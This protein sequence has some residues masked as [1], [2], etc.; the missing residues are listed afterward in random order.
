MDFAFPILSLTLI[1]GGLTI[2]VSYISAEQVLIL[3]KRARPTEDLSLRGM[4]ERVS[5]KMGVKID[6]VYELEEDQA[7]AYA[8]DSVRKIVI[9][10]KSILS[11]VNNEELESIM[12]HEVSHIKA[13]HGLKRAI[14]K[15]IS[16]ITLGSLLFY[17]VPILIIIAG[18]FLTLITDIYFSKTTELEA[19]I[20]ASK[21]VDKYA[22][23]SAISKLSGEESLFSTH[24]A[25]SRRISSILSA[26]P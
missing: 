11:H 17:G 6:Q 21:I 2:I 7:N 24:P 19:D 1:A 9:I 8:V 10:S 12:A 23:I 18:L 26:N 4:V 22:L 16:L 20:S 3:L 15:G 5:D 14:F 25:A 13:R